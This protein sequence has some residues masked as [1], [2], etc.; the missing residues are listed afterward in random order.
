[1]GISPVQLLIVLLI[2]LVLFGTKKLRNVGADLG[3]AVRGFKKAVNDGSGESAESDP[4]AAKIE[5]SETTEDSVKH[6]TSEKQA[7]RA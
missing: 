5:H 7:D 2:V 1:M 4:A 3:A 6:P